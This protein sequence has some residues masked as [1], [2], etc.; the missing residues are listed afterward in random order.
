MVQELKKTR[1]AFILPED[2]SWT[3]GVNYLKN[4]LFAVKTAGLDD[5]EPI[6]YVGKKTDEK[7][8]ELF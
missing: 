5:F 6:L 4:L 3:G 7:H 2:Q 1:I 8:L